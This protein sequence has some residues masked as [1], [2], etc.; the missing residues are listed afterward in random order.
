[1][2]THTRRTT[3]ASGIAA[4]VLAL[5]LA[6]CQSAVDLEESP[7]ATPAD[8]GTLTIAQ[9]SDAQPNNVQAGRLGNAAWA[10]NVF[11]T[12][13]AYDADGTPQPLLATDW[14]VADDQMSIDITLRDDVAFHTG[15][16]MT[17]ED[18]KY[19][20]EQSAQSR[21]QV[22]YIAKMFT[23]VDV[24]SATELTIRFSQPIPNIFDFFEQT[25][26]LDQETSA[27]LAD[28][29]Q[30]IG[31]GAFLFES[32]SPGSEVK[33]V[34]N[35]DYWGEKPHL[36]G[37]DIA[38]ITDSTAMLNAVRSGRSQVALGMNAQ[39]VQ[40]IGTSTGYTIVDTDGTVYP[41]GIDVTQAPFDTKEARQ[42][43][44]YAID[45]E[46]IASQIFGD[47]AT[48]TSLF[49]SETA[50]GYP[51]DLDEHYAYDPDKA[52]QMLEESGAAGAD[53][54]ISVIS[55]PSNTSVAEIVRNNL[56]EVGLNPTINAVETQGFDQRQ[57]AGD[58]GQMFMPLHGLN[59]LAPITL[60][61][62]LP[63]LREGNPSH[64]W[65]DEYEQLRNELLTAAD[66]EYADALHALSEYILDQAFS[67][68][69]VR[70]DGQFVQASS[71][72]D[73]VWTS[74]S[75]LDAK[76]AFVTE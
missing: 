36:D 69:V 31:T 71:A 11:E 34:R 61:N 19:S 60:M 55:L 20:V 73:L 48:A 41:L 24:V 43:V 40:T 15:R 18:V 62:T 75:Y 37:I 4:G 26:I 21:A 5:S 17:A 23:A 13:T 14:T 25:F 28:G 16:T 57:I 38:V 54:T 51:S 76:T 64:F 10:A 50:T 72:H 70:V 49:W 32:W 30:V 59:G 67:T 7:S 63:S 27:G 8:G 44:N 3:L 66:D 1:M 29:T 45:R 9:S 65:T 47:S 39:D 58:L 74:R 68:N 35:D 46:R 12:L 6:G 33:L 2:F 52:K 42:A 53:V 56:E 22:G